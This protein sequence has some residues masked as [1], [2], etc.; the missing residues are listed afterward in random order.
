MR[1]ELA[2]YSVCTEQVVKASQGH[3]P[4]PFLIRDVL[5]TV[6]NIVCAIYFENYFIGDHE[7]VMKFPHQTLS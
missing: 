5:R 1:M 6:A 4:Q 2:P 3:F 7:E